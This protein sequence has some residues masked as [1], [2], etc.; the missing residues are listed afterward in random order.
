MRRSTFVL[1]AGV[2]TLVVTVAGCSVSG[3]VFTGINV[4]KNTEANQLGIRIWLDGSEATRDEFKQAATGYS[5]YTVDSGVG[6]NPK[7][8]FEFKEPDALGRITS[9]IV[10][11]HQKF[12]AD[13]SHQA[14][15]TIFATSNDPQAQLKPGVVYD[16]GNLPAGFRVTDYKGDTV[17]G[18]ALK[19]GVQYMM[20]LTVRADKSETAQI[21]FKT[22]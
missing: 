14:E 22:N 17:N 13:Y 21:Y 7:L 19:N 18:V 3:A 9:V 8:K 10:N 11:I 5:R 4:Y 16:L 2:A 1:F 6:T 15:F 12:E 20:N